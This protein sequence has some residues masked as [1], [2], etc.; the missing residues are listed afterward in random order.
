VDTADR[1]EEERRRIRVEQGAATVRGSRVETT[2]ERVQRLQNQ[3]HAAELLVDELVEE[4][5][6]ER[7]AEAET[8]EAAKTARAR[9]AAIDAEVAAAAAGFAL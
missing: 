7:I 9:D 1:I 8:A 4:I 2:E 5:E 3:A 6:Q